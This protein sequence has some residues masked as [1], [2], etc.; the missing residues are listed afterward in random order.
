MCGKAKSG[1]SKARWMYELKA[2]L[3]DYRQLHDGFQ[4]EL[5]ETYIYHPDTDPETF[6][7][8]LEESRNK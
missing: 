6:V 5:V 8:R 1:A 2:E 3:N 4:F 7:R